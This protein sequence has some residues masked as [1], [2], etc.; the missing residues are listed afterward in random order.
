M[1][2]ERYGTGVANLMGGVRINVS[3]ALLSYKQTTRSGINHH[4]LLTGRTVFVAQEYR[5]I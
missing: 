1:C 5:K 3:G 4:G 2:L